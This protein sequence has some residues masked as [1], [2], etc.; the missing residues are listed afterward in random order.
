[1][2]AKADQ[3]LIHTEGFISLNHSVNGPIAPWRV[4]STCNGVMET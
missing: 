2:Y 3:W 4:K 1:M